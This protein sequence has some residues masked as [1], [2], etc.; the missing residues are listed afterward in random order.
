MTSMSMRSLCKVLLLA[1]PAL[2]A[3]GCMSNK[4]MVYLQD[5]AQARPH[6]ATPDHKFDQ[7]FEAIRLQHGD[8]VSVQID[9]YRLTREAELVSA[10]EDVWWRTAEY[11]Y[12]VGF[13]VTDSGIVDLPTIGK[14]MVAGL[15]I[16][17][18]QDKVS[19]LART[20]YENPAVKI[21]LINFMVSVVGEVNTPG[22]YR[23]FTNRIS[24]MEA[25]AMAN[26]MTPYANRSN[27]RVLRT[28]GTTNHIFPMD[29]NDEQVLTSPSLWLQ[30]GDVLVVNPLKRKK[31]TSRDP[32]VAVQFMG[33]LVSLASLFVILNQ[34]K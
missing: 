34:G 14:V 4:K 30:P 27:V 16:D 18:A 13:P 19:D 33:V 12:L 32:F 28:R 31:F 2:G 8:I 5:K 6:D 26:D 7:R 20:Y 15:T 25:L 21:F 11:P 22:R 23:V 17:E 24:V 3:V 1:L 29:L 10:S 9:H